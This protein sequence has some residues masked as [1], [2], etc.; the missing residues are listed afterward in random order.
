MTTTRHKIAEQLERALEAL[1][2]QFSMAAYDRYTDEYRR[3]AE[4]YRLGRNGRDMDPSERAALA[5]AYE[6]QARVR[7]EYR[8]HFAA[9]VA[10]R[11]EEAS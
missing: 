2:P 7:T 1:H 8:H 5:R 3:S 4:A 10:A 11:E 9:A 6:M